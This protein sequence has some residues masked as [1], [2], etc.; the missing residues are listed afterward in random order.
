MCTAP[1][2]SDLD[3]AEWALLCPLLTPA[4]QAGH[5]QVLELRR[6]VEAVFYLLRTG[7]QWRSIPREFPS[8]P[9]VYWHY[10]KWRH[11]GTWE[12]INTALRERQRIA[13]GRAAQPTAAIIDSQSVRSTEAGGPRGYDGGKKIIGR[14]R[15][16]LVDTQGHLLKARV[17]PADLHDRRGAEALLFGLAARFPLIVLLWADTAYRGLRQWLA[18]TLGW[19]LSV[20]KHPWT[21]VQ[22]VWVA[23]GQQPPPIPRGFHVLPRRWVVERTLAWISRNRRMA[24][25]YERLT[26]TSEML[27]YMAMA[28]VMLR[29]LA[30]ATT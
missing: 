16:I 5:P 18:D 22:G 17:H 29:R 19:T 11:A 21:G 15:H 26:Q 10:A 1:Y 6:I 23:P 2:P 25:D 8:W 20:V 4:R 28:R 12:E 9:A 13:I 27:V 3:D 30:R 7:C 14:K 24:K